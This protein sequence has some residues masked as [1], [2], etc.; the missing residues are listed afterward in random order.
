MSTTT[1][2]IPWREVTDGTAYTGEP[3]TNSVQFAENYQPSKPVFDVEVKETVVAPTG[4]SR[5]TTTDK[6]LWHKVADGPLLKRWAV[7]LTKGNVP[8][9]DVAPGVPNWTLASTEPERQRFLE[10]AYR[11][12]MDWY[13][14]QLWKVRTKEDNAA[15]VVFN[16]NGV[17]YCNEKIHPEIA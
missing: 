13:Y 9:P 3:K 2:K 17:E 12:F 4:M 10:S 6:I 15:A 16:I 1:D 11:H 7:H 8:Y 5:S 14:C